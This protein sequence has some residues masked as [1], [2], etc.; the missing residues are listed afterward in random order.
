MGIWF[1]NKG[2]LFFDFYIVVFLFW[3]YCVVI[4][5]VLNIVVERF[6]VKG[7]VEEYFSNKEYYELGLLCV[8]LIFVEFFSN[9]GIE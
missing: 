4:V 3:C 1:C 5:N 7:I 9:L 6:W 8:C 2:F